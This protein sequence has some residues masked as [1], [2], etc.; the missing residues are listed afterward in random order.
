MKDWLFDVDNLTMLAAWAGFALSIFQLLKSRTSIRLFLGC[1][2]DEDRIDVSN[3]SAH[4]VTLSSAGVVTA[5]GRL[6]M[7][8]DEHS[9]E[10]MISPLLP[11]RLKARDEIILEVPFINRAY[12][13]KVHHRGG[14]YVTTSDGK[15]FSDVSWLRR[16]WWWLLSVIL[17]DTKR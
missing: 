10:Y 2:L 3:L 17:R 14:V 12:H 8:S 13:N 11:R 7:L 5:S 9:D 16:R 1:D 4:D 6:R 15:L